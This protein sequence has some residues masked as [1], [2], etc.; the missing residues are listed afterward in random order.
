MRE[1]PAMPSSRFRRIFMEKRRRAGPES[2]LVPGAVFRKVRSDHV[3][4]TAT[5]LAVL[6]DGAGV[7]HV[8]Y[9]VTFHTPARVPYSEDRR[10]LSLASFTEYFRERVPA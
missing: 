1:V 10:L 4:E 2:G 7:P 9:D 5:V 3:I 8:R 6:R